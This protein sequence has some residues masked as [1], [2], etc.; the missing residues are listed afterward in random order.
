[1]AVEVTKEFHKIYEKVCAIQHAHMI[2]KEDGQ[3]ADEISR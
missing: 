2:W 3:W 1:M